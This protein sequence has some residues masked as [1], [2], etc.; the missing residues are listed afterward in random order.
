MSVTHRIRAIV[1]ICLIAFA[2]S[3]LAEVPAVYRVPVAAR[4]VLVQM[5][6]T[7]RHGQLDGAFIAELTREEVA[8]E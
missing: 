2:T 1:A 7:V 3:A 8:S 5:K 6:A 4:D